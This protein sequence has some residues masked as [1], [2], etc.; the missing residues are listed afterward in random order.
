MTTSLAL[1][2]ARVGAPVT[3]ATE[4]RIPIGDLT[5]LPV[6]H[7]TRREGRPYTLQLRKDRDL[8]R[9]EAEHR[10]RAETILQELLAPPKAAK[11]GRSRS[12][13][14]RERPAMKRRGRR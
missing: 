5:R 1:L 13:E 9:R 8:F 14:K 6:L 2:L 10:V 4:G 12:A 7:A 11:S 3:F